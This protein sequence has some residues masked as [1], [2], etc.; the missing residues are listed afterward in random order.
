LRSGREPVSRETG[1][2][3]AAA[4]FSGTLDDLAVAD[5][6]QIVQLLGKS[7]QIT[8]TRDGA[9]SHLWCR[10]GELIDAQSG[11]ARGEAALFRVLS[12][13]RGWLVAE[14]QPVE[15]TRTIFG[16]SQQLLLEAARR[17]DELVR[18]GEPEEPPVDS[19]P[20]DLH[21]RPAE[22]S[23][24]PIAAEPIAEL[25]QQAASLPPLVAQPRRSEPPRAPRGFAW[26]ALASVLLVPGAY[27]W[28]AHMAPVPPPAPAAQQ[29]AAPPVIEPANYN[30]DV[31]AEPETA[32]LWLDGKLVA[33]GHLSTSQPRDGASHELSVKAPG[34]APVTI[35][36]ADAAPP[37]L[38]RL[39]RL[40]AA[41]TQADDALSAAVRGALTTSAK[42]APAPAAAA[43]APGRPAVRG[44][45]NPRGRNE[46]RVKVIGGDE[47]VVR[48][49]D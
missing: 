16:T 31:S 43:P 8:V 13:E 14:L 7:A 9:E 41:R 17:K 45:S 29:L 30:V 47:P 21:F 37:A 46:P 6:L 4:R 25:A 35:F 15:R 11:S 26:L 3:P 22:L 44:K 49:L 36:F 19:V 33:T 24:E 1:R 40:P 27:F 42:G 10:D 48:V 12:F 38:V 39:E 32:E 20:G 34:Y 2:Q 18:R 5:L 23:A 28:G